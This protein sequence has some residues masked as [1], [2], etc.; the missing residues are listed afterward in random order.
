M[1]KR[2]PNGMLEEGRNMM[3]KYEEIED[4]LIEKF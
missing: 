3:N 2:Q 4:K 1:E